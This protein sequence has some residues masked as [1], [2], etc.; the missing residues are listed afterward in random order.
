M[1]YISSWLQRLRSADAG[2]IGGCEVDKSTKVAADDS[3]TQD[4]SA[5]HVSA[6]RLPMERVC[7]VIADARR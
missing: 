5:C 6:D 7:D 4:Q 1:R 2:R 3:H